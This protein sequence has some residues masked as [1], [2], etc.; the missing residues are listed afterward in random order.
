MLQTLYIRMSRRMCY[1]MNPFIWSLFNDRL[2][3]ITDVGIF[4]LPVALPF[5][6]GLPFGPITAS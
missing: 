6:L 4:T 5:P 3:F 1:E 2:R